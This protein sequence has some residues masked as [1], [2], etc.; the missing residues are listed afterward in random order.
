MLNACLKGNGLSRY[1]L[2]TDARLTIEGDA[3]AVDE[4]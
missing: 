1:V 4:A 2:V 3:P